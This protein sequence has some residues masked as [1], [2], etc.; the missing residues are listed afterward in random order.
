[1]CVCVWCKS[2]SIVAVFFYSIGQLGLAKL[3]FPV[4]Y[5]RA[6]LQTNTTTRTE[7]T[8]VGDKERCTVMYVC[9]NIMTIL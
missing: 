4:A 1:M 2:K 6:P 7:E 3:V 5:T 8:R 9:I